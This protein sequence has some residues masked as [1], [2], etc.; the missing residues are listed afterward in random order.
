VRGTEHRWIAAVAVGCHLAAQE[1]RAGVA[2]GAPL[3][4]AGLAA[5]TANVPDLLEPAVHPHHRQFFHSCLWAGL[6][7]CGL[8]GIADWEPD[9]S[10]MRNLRFLLLVA[11]S[12]YLIHL[13]VDACTSR[14]IP[15]VGKVL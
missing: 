11:G 8:R 1:T 12:A 7:G 6:L 5:L 3:V 15:W 10:T 14:S 2:T 9:D 4:G 13:A